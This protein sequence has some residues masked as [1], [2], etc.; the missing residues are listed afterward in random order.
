MYAES[1]PCGSLSTYVRRCVLNT[2]S[3]FQKIDPIVSGLGYEI[4]DVERGLSR[5]ELSRN[6]QGLRPSERRYTR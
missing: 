6:R 5:G 3:V 2:E 4:V 1:E